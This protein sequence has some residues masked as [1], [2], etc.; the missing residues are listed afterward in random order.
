M[1]LFPTSGEGRK[2]STLLSPL[3]RANLNLSK[4]PNGVGAFL[5]SPEDGNLEFKK[6]CDL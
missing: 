6:C 4:W 5:L 3:E 2:T 1:N